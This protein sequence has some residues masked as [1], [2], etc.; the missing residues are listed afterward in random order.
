MLQ[1]Y[2]D[3]QENNPIKDTDRYKNMDT[4]ENKYQEIDKCTSVPKNT[5]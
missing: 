5:R 3:L 2:M 4:T 1:P